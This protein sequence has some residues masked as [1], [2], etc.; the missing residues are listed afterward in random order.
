VSKKVSADMFGMALRTYQR[1][2]QRLT[3][4][5]TER[6][7]SLWEAVLE[8]VGKSVVTR[9]EVFS[10]FR[11]DDEASVRGVLRDLTE[12]SLVF[13]TGSGRSTGYRS[14]TPEESGALRRRDDV[15]GLEALVWTAVFREQPVSVERLASACALTRAELEPVLEALMATGRIQRMSPESAD[16][17]A[18]TLLLGFEDPPGW[19]A[20]VLDHFSTVARTILQKLAIDQQARRADQVGGSTYHFE[21]WRNHPLEDEVL[22]ELERF[23]ERM[24]ALRDRVDAHNGAHP[25][26]ERRLRVDAYYGQTVTEEDDDGADE[27]TA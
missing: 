26:Q 6:G 14:A 9:E 23:R 18:E 11:H 27:S 12:S 15:V 21:L 8:F 7:R 22:G 5:Q 1:R 16:Y 24:S 17:R 25:T 4:S 19:E 2:T 13:S 10:R 20:A 3:Q